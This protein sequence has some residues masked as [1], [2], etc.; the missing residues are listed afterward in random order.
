[1]SAVEDREMREFEQKTPKSKAIY[2]NAKLEAPFGV[3]SNYRYSDPYPL[4]FTRGKGSRLWDVDG[5]EYTDY[6]MGFGVLVAGHSHP[7]VVQAIK[8]QLE[9]GTDL[10]FEWEETPKYCRMICERFGVD[11]VKL[12]NTGAEATMYAVRFASAFTGRNKI[13]KFVGCYHC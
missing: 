3:H 12:S 7:L 10:G 6:N 8:E 4:Y 2:A 11:Q 9:K 5:N 13:V 1:L